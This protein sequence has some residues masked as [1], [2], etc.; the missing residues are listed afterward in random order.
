M[1]GKQR[2]RAVGPFAIALVLWGC[3]ARPP[4]APNIVLVVIDTARADHFSTYGYERQTT[5]RFTAFARDGIL[6]ESA[7]G[8]S[9]W[10]LP[11]HASLFTGVHPATHRA[12]HE[13]PRLDD[14]FHTLAELLSTSGYETI[15]FTNNPW[16]SAHTNLVQGFQDVREM[17]AADS[18]APDGEGH[19]TNRAI[20][21]WLESR[22]ARRPFFLFVNY[23]EPHWP[24][25]P[26]DRYQ[27]LFL[28]KDVGDSERTAANFRVVDWY[29][30]QQQ[31]GPELLRIRT[32][33]Y[34]AEL[35]FA[36]QVLGAL[37]DLLK[38]HGVWQDSLIVVTQ[39][40][41][42]GRLR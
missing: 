11:S 3:D 42:Q 26:P 20:D 23:I 15:A 12:N 21:R 37:L 35:A 36:D 10:T 38:T 6:F 27:D 34:D 1:G 30:T 41:Q 19:A 29:L 13:T 28:S 31:P 2:M 9:S 22:G 32:A 25:V 7:Y 39:G 8:T 33:L 17:W 5:P 4:S 40:S 24:Y 16:V 14:R 18:L